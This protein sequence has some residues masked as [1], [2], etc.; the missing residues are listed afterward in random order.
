MIYGG[1]Y[2]ASYF[3]QLNSP[4]VTE[5]GRPPYGVE[6]E[7]PVDASVPD[8]ILA[9]LGAHELV[10]PPEFAVGHLP[11]YDGTWFHD[12]VIPHGDFAIGHEPGHGV[13]LG[14]NLG[15]TLT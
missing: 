7:A 1:V 9:L 10:A 8:E 6:L 4:V 13:R 12:G 5:L 3:L 14:G 15:V 11:S 2:P